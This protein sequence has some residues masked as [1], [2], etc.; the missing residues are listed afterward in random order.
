ML[1]SMTLC[2]CYAVARQPAFV[3]TA[4]ATPAPLRFANVRESLE[5]S[6]ERMRL[7]EETPIAMELLNRN[8]R[9]PKKVRVVVLLRL[10]RV[11]CP[12]V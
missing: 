12:I 4:V 5:A 11:L 2:V 8:A 1:T 3:N 10:P 7:M 6:F 9:R